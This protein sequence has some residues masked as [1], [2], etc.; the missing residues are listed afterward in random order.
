MEGKLYYSFRKVL[1][2]KLNNGKPMAER[3]PRVLLLEAPDWAGEGE[4][5]LYLEVKLKSWPMM[6]SG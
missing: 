2:D 3:I 1:L 6:I 4:Q 5:V